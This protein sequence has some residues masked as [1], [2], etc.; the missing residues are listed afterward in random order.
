[1]EHRLRVAI[2]VELFFVFVFAVLAGSASAQLTR[3][4]PELSTTDPLVVGL[5]DP[6]LTCLAGTTGR[7][8]ATPD[9]VA[10]GTTITLSWTATKPSGC[11]WAPIYFRLEGHAGISAVSASGSRAHQPIANETLLLRARYLDRELIIASTYVGVTLP[12]SLYIYGSHLGPQLHQALW[13]TDVPS[14]VITLADHVEIDLTRYGTIV[15]APGVTLQGGRSRLNRGPKIYSTA[16]RRYGMLRINGDNVRIRGLR[17]AGPDLGPVDGDEVSR[18]I[19]IEAANNVEISNNDIYGWTSVAIEVQDNDSNRIPFTGP[20]YTIRIRENFIHHNQHVG[21]NGYGVATRYGG[22]A[23]I[24]R[25]VFDWNRHAIAADARPTSGYAAHANLVLP[26]GGLHEPVP[27]TGLWFY[28]HQFD[29]HGTDTCL[30]IDHNCGLA[31]HSFYITHNTFMYTKDDAIRLRGTPQLQPYGMFVSYNMFAHGDLGDA[32]TQTETGLHFGPGNVTNNAVQ[33]ARGVCD[34]DADGIADDFMTTGATWWYKSGGVVQW[35]YLNT[36]TA[37]LPQMALG[38][39][40]GD[41]RCDVSVGGVI[42]SGG[43]T[44]PAIPKTLGIAIG[45]LTLR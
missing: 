17:I 16:R 30:G 19:L 5:P 10:L 34:F 31:G 42:Y 1:M 43:K 13:Q 35:S 37:R 40:D 26:N 25:N 14:R 44:A 7:L 3:P 15:V 36:S 22:Y 29:A 38:Y 18:G 21:G 24:E 32:V 20:P 33:T 41:A 23:L 4:I 9:R 39:F 27:F 2:R 11:A 45:G 6:G 28:T 8:Y 12:Q